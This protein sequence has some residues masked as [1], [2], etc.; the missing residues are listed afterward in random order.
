LPLTPATA[1]VE[2]RRNER[3]QSHASQHRRA[4][5]RQARPP[6]GRPC[7]LQPAR[8]DQIVVRN[9]AVAINPLDWVI[10]AEGTI[11]Y[12]WLKY[13]AVLGSDVF[14]E[15]VEA[16]RAVTRFRSAIGC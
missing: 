14:G 9:H 4:D 16:G 3:G 15:V 12:G 8:D 1:S 11:T 7:A 10:Q 6:R 5:Q 2:P 13:P